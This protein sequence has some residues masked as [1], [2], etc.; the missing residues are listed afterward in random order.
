MEIK[1]GITKD[2]AKNQLYEMQ[3][4]EKSII[5]TI[6]TDQT[7]IEDKI[8]AVIYDASTDQTRYQHLGR[9]THYNVFVA[10]TTA[11]QLAIET[12]R[13]NHERTEWRIYTDN[14]SINNPQRQSGQAII[15]DFLDCVDDIKDKHPHLHIKIIWIPGH[16]DIDGNERAD[17]EAKKAAINPPTS[18]PYNRRPLK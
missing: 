3:K 9:D 5:A 16:A 17:I 6:Y 10:K 2:E 12:L 8:G 7:G 13:D 11:L 14:Q 4:H 15:K 1:I 18:R